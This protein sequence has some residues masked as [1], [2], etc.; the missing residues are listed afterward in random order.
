VLAH[1]THT[2]WHAR[3]LPNPLLHDTNHLQVVGATIAVIDPVQPSWIV[4]HVVRYQLTVHKL[5]HSV[6]TVNL[7][8]VSSCVGCPSQ[9]CCLPSVSSTSPVDRTQAPAFSGRCDPLACVVMRW[10][11]LTAVLSAVCVVTPC[12][13]PIHGNTEGS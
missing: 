5:P 8:R 4:T 12:S 9:Q 2:H 7:S 6:A 3:P 10:L 11:P 1:H 13:T